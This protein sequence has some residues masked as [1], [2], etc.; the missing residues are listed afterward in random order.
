[1]KKILY[2]LISVAAALGVVS[3]QE[4]YITYSGPEYMMF[5]DTLSTNMVLADG[6][7]FKVP[8][9]STVKCDYDRTFGVEVID[10]GSNAVEGKHFSLKSHSVTI[11]AGK[12]TAEVEV[13]G[14]YDN[15][16]PTDS[17][18]FVLKL[19]MPEQLKWNEL[20]EGYDRTKVVMYKSC[21]FDINNFT[22]WC[23]LSSLFVYS[24][25]GDNA[26]YQRLIRT[27]LHPTEENSIILRNAL[28]DGYDI[29]ITFDPEDPA[30]PAVTMASGQ[31]LSDEASV[32]GWILGDDHIL[33]E[34]SP[35]YTSY[36]NSCQRF[37][38]LWMHV[39]VEKVGESIGSVGHFLNVLEWV[40][41][42]EADRLQREDGM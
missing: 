7:T 12:L 16:E 1:M 5:P 28:Y 9:A 33:A 19:V 38:E 3:C 34:Q 39:Y 31:V 22:G 26:S 15:I 13:Q 20:Y 29:T 25:P 23:M 42:E 6:S 18:G 21:P 17:L 27:E 35:Y 40:S 32:L 2:T 24:Y 10:A 30:K 14:Y 37:V 41:D 11:P 8:V 36:F 4:Q